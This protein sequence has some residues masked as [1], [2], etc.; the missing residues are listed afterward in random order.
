[1]LLFTMLLLAL[2][3]H[4]AA[5]YLKKNEI[6]HVSYLA[7]SPDFINNKPDLIK[8]IGVLQSDSVPIEVSITHQN[9][10]I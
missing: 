7:H 10:F 3:S 5:I 1:M 9:L 2:T 6:L 4:I 8:L